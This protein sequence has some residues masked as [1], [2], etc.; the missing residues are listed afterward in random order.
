MPA[1]QPMRDGGGNPGHQTQEYSMSDESTMPLPRIELVI[2]EVVDG[3]NAWVHIHTGST[4]P[5]MPIV[6]TVR[7]IEQ[8]QSLAQAIARARNIPNSSIFTEI[9]RS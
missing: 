8:A 2:D 7:T 6:E 1:A 9:K 3:Y 5:Q 4:E